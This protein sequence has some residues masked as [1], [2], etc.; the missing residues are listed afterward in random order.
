MTSRDLSLDFV[1]GFLVVCMIIYHVISYFTNAG[2]SGTQYVRFVTGAFIMTSGYIVSVFYRDK[3]SLDKNNTCVRLFV[4]GIKLL[5]IFTVLNLLVNMFNIQSHKHV[6]YNLGLFIDNLHSIYV[7]GKSSLA[8]FQILVPIAYLLIISPV[9]LVYYEHKSIMIFFILCLLLCY[10]F[11]DLNL[12]NLYGLI[13]G[14]AG[15]AAGATNINLNSYSIK[16]QSVIIIIFLIMMTLMKYFDRSIISYCIAIIIIMKLSYDFSKNIKQESILHRLMVLL[17][18]YA[19]L[20]YL[21]HILFLQFIS[22]L[23][24]RKRFTV[25][26][27][28]ITIF[29]GTLVFLTVVCLLLD[30]LRHRFIYIDKSYKFIFS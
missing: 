18:Q 4:R 14:M 3:F 22:L 2:Y 7:S 27:E 11:F 15:F 17:G 8:I 21:L 26:L 25:G 10:S 23:I 13:I 19:L 29:V 20:G 28:V 16:F 6:T 1:K 12:F 5:L 24:M 30:K 9:L